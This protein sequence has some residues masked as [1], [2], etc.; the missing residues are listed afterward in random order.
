M[1][2]R[3]E[4]FAEIKLPAQAVEGLIKLNRGKRDEQFDLRFM[5]GMLIGFCTVKKIK[6]YNGNED[7][8]ESV[9]ALMKG[10]IYL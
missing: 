5:K 10:I 1:V 6:E 4:G 8:D 9:S 7:I 2:P 3:G